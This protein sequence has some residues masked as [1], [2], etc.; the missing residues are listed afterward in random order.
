M[1]SFPTNWY[2][3]FKRAMFGT[4]PAFSGSLGFKKIKVVAN[5][6]TIISTQ[7]VVTELKSFIVF[8]LFLP[9][10]PSCWSLWLY[11]FCFL[12]GG[13]KISVRHRPIGHSF[14]DIF[15]KISHNVHFRNISTL[16]FV[17]S[18]IVKQYKLSHREYFLARS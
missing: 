1:D 12:V 17:F 14:Q 6:W 5:L 16:F 9:F 13:S 15:M 4:F 8:V 2:Q 10:V 18:L 3:N 11:F 7:S